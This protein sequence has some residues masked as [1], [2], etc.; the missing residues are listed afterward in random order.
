[1]YIKKS[2]PCPYPVGKNYYS[3]HNMN[4]VIGPKS[5]VTLVIEAGNFDLNIFQAQ[6]IFFKT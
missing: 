2:N 4:E 5:Q 6:T 3:P 1:M